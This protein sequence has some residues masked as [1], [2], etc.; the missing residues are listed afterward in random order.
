MAGFWIAIVAYYSVYSF[1]LIAKA[2]HM[3]KKAQAETGE[4]DV[5][6]APRFA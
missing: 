5:P 6:H 2:A 3:R 1:C 4:C